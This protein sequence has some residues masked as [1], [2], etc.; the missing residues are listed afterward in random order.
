MSDLERR[1]SSL[2]S[3]L[4]ISSPES[5]M[6]AVRRMGTRRK[7]VRYSLAAVASVTLVGFVAVPALSLL[8]DKTEV[9]TV[10]GGP[11]SSE[12]EP[13]EPDVADGISLSSF[14]GAP[15]TTPEGVTP[16]AMVR[17][18][19]QLFAVNDT[20]GHFFAVSLPIGLVDAPTVRVRPEIQL[21]LEGGGVNQTIAPSGADALVQER[22]DGT[23]TPESARSSASGGTVTEWEADWYRLNVTTVQFDDWAVLLEGPDLAARQLLAESISIEVAA[24]GLP[25]V[26]VDDARVDA[27]KPEALRISFATPEGVPVTIDITQGC[28]SVSAFDLEWNFSDLSCKEDMLLRVSSSDENLAAAAFEGIETIPLDLD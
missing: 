28:S 25:V 16:L 7:V 17:D 12:V 24:T 13:V 26:R 9:V 21:G 22:C 14:S 23:C 10:T 19:A 15:A 6:P 18:G 20:T 4:P 5:A 3:D 27:T 1:L 11:D 2:G 8:S